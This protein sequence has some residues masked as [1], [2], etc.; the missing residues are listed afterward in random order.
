MASAGQKVTNDPRAGNFINEAVGTVTSDSL[1]GE[2]LKRGGH[3]G[4]GNPKAAASKQPSSSTNTNNTD[5]SGARKIESAPNSG[6]RED[7]KPY[8]E[9]KEFDAGIGEGKDAGRGPTYATKGGT[10]GDAS[11]GASR[12][13][14]PSTS[15]QHIGGSGNAPGAVVTSSNTTSSSSGQ[16]SNASAQGGAAPT[17]THVGT[18][19]SARH[20]AGPKGKSLKEGGDIKGNEPNASFN[21]DIGTQDDPGRV[22]ENAFA[23]RNTQ[24]AH[25]T[26]LQGAKDSGKSEGVYDKLNSDEAT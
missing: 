1:A 12:S 11:G 7:A 6:R 23:K 24:S 21:S 9:K 17:G 16:T 13:E 25:D 22:A 20:D 5:T 19:G 10:T 26:A 15:G 3:F 14:A 18:A 2:S 8:D 4:E